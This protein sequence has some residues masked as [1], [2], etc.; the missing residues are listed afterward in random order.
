[1]L[2]QSRSA[3][4]LCAGWGVGQVDQVCAAQAYMLIS[5]PTGSSTIFGA[6]QDIFIPRDFNVNSIARL[7]ISLSAT[8]RLESFRHWAD[9]S[10]PSRNN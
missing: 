8:R 2:A 9:R 3:R 1:M 10:N 4:A 7:T 6:F 5:M